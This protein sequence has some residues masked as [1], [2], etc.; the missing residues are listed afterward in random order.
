MY[1]NLKYDILSK[2][3]RFEQERVVFLRIR[4]AA[5]WR[6]QDGVAP[7][8]KSMYSIKYQTRFQ[9]AGVEASLSGRLPCHLF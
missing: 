4:P 6:I 9:T 2:R 5:R 7:G 3:I 8:L 1:N